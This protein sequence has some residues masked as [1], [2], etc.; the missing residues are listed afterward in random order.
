MYMSTILTSLKTADTASTKSS[1]N[2]CFAAWRLTRYS[3]SS[4]NVNVLCRVYIPRRQRHWRYL[5]LQ[6]LHWNGRHVQLLLLRAC[7]RNK[8]RSASH[9]LHRLSY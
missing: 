5:S 4:V 2:V 3:I 7:S 9:S 8:N 1:I 6:R